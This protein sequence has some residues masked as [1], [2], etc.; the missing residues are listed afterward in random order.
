MIIDSIIII[1]RTT[2]KIP[3]CLFELAQEGEGG[4][5]LLPVHVPS[6]NKTNNNNKKTT[7]N[8]GSGDTTIIL[9]A[10]S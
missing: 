1:M 6:V 10:S 9:L 5:S 4:S 2:L 8:K 3:L 7:N